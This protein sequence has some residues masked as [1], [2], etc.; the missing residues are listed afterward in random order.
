MEV[1]NTDWSTIFPDSCNVDESV[2]ILYDKLYTSI[3][4][5]VPLN[6]VKSNDYAVKI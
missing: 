2:D 4:S 3:N 1:A 5:F 6:R